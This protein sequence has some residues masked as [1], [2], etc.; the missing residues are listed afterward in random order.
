MEVKLNIEAK[1]Q[2]LEQK[3]FTYTRYQ[4]GGDRCPVSFFCTKFLISQ[5]IIN[6]L[7]Y[8]FLYTNG[9]LTVF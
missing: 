5:K 9:I 4:S 2:I 6:I 1:A 3:R 8:L 7:T